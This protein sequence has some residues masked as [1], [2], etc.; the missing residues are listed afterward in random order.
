[1]TAAMIMALALCSLPANHRSIAQHPMPT[2]R[3]ELSVP[4]P[5]IEKDVSVAFVINLSL[6]E[7]KPISAEKWS[8]A[9]LTQSFESLRKSAMELLCKSRHMA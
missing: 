4:T 9:I 2:L 3:L 1:M 7:T 6:D 5:A 8:L